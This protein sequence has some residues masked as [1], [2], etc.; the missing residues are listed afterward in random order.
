MHVVPLSGSAIEFL[1]KVESVKK[2]LDYV[3]VKTFNPGEGE[4]LTCGA[5]LTNPK[6]R[7]G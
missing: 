5:V 6:K 2:K 3:K 4:C 1:E 7:A